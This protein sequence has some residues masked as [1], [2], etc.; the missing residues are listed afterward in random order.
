VLGRDRDVRVPELFRHVPELHTGC[1]EL[2]GERVPQILEASVAN[3][4]ALEDAAPLDQTEDAGIADGQ[5]V[6]I[7]S[8]LESRTVARAKCSEK[9][10]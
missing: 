1:Q 8:G 5:D 9:P 6:P 7:G 2:A 3:R 4:G 10:A